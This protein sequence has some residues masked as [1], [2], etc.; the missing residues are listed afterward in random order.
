MATAS[1]WAPVY[2]ALD[3]YNYRKAG[4]LLDKREL[5]TTALGKALR[6]VVYLRSGLRTD[7]LGVALEVLR[8]K[9]TDPAVLN[10]LGEVFARTDDLGY[11]VQL[12]DGAAAE[13]PEDEALGRLQAWAWARVEDH[14]KM[15]AVRSWRCRGSA[16]AATAPAR[17]P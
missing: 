16:R 7:A 3:E 10:A 12:F 11:F 4:S 8:S 9:P 17:R 1:K 5:A 14:K 15:Q 13:R 6:A 2:A